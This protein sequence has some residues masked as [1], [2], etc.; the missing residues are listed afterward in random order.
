MPEPVLTN[1]QFKRHY[2]ENDWESCWAAKIDTNFIPLDDEYRGRLE[3]TIQLIVGRPKRILD[4]GCGIGLYDIAMAKALPD[5]R[6]TAMDISAKQLELGK[7]LAKKADVAPNIE[8]L[9]GDAE[10]F[11][12]DE[13]FDLIVCTEVL[14]HFVK[15]ETVLNNIYRHCHTDTQIIFSVPQYYGTGPG[16]YYRACLPNG[17]MVEDQDKRKIPPN[18]EVHEFFHDAYTPKRLKMF[19]KKN[20]F[21]PQKLT[22]AVYSPFRETPLYK[23]NVF[24]QTFDRLIRKLNHLKIF[25]DQLSDWI[26]CHRHAAILLASCKIT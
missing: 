21:I 26:T 13:K 9:P 23:L 5:S 24:V 19:L 18:C 10:K 8:F 16:L 15:P 2:Q 1:E 7:E 20:N 3:G 4:I 11:N 14:E 12:L 22:G 17:Q 25:P 6:I